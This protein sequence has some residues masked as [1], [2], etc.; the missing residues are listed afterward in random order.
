[1]TDRLSSS[2]SF[3]LSPRL[4]LSLCLSASCSLPPSPLSLSASLSVSLCLSLC[5]CL[6][7]SLSLCLSFSLSLSLS[8]SVSLCLSLSVF[9]SLSLSV[10]LFL[11]F[12]PSISPSLSLSVSLYLS[13]SFSKVVRVSLARAVL[14]SVSA[15]ERSVNIARLQWGA[16]RIVPLT[17]PLAF[18]LPLS[19]LSL[20]RSISSSCHS[21]L[22]P[23]LIIH[24]LSSY[25][26]TFSL[27]QCPLTPSGWNQR[28]SHTTTLTSHNNL[29]VPL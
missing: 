1:V 5:L 10:S 7:L 11:P 21:P 4:C 22:R 23:R 29:C 6:Y 15:Q 19:S 26:V 25:S 17:S 14:V 13:L 28:G 20:S 2:P 24:F 8:V 16:K 18:C 12:L 27:S 3:L 9:L